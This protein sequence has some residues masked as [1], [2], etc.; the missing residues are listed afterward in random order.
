MKE[1]LTSSAMIAV[2]TRVWKEVLSTT[3]SLLVPPLSDKPSSQQQLTE[4]E[5]ETVFK[6]LSM[7]FDFFH[8]VDEST[9]QANGVPLD[10]LKSPK[11]HDLQNLNF[12]Y[13]EPTDNLIRT[14][15]RMA[16]ATADRNNPS[17][18]GSA[19]TSSN[20]SHHG[21]QSA[22][23]PLGGPHATTLASTP[24]RRNKSV[25][26]SRN[27]GTMRKAKEEK[28]REAQAEPSDDMILRILRMRPE[29]TRYLRDRSR[30]RERLAAAA[31]ADFI[32]RQSLEQGAAR[33]RQFEKTKA[34]EQARPGAGVPLRKSVVNS[35][36]L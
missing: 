33:R 35:S 26:Y 36:D 20:I 5:V 10:V 18:Q 17:S 22:P 14:S 32:V 7:L 29:A 21:R 31:A 16:A 9:R 4:I 6:W 19:R 3:E 30:Q 13:F 27:L 25:M 15:E 34:Q 12:F 28:R 1:T 8:A 23:A 24:A 11:Y 2:M